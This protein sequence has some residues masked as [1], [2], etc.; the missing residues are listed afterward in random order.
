MGCIVLTFFFLS[1]LQELLHS[2]RR[3]SLKVLSFVQSFQV[4]KQNNRVDC[5]LLFFSHPVY[6]PSTIDQ[7]PCLARMASSPLTLTAASQTPSVNPR[8]S[9]GFPCQPATSSSRTGSWRSGAAG[10]LLLSTSQLS[11][12]TSPHKPRKETSRSSPEVKPPPPDIYIPD[13]KQTDVQSSVG[14]QFKLPRAPHGSSSV[15]QGHVIDEWC[16]F[17]GKHHITRRQNWTGAQTL[18]LTTRPPQ[19]PKPTVRALDAAWFLNAA[20]PALH[21]ILMFQVLK[22]LSGLL[23]EYASFPDQVCGPESKPRPPR[24]LL[25]SSQVEWS[26]AWYRCTS[27][28]FLLQHP[29][30]GAFSF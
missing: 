1:S 18:S 7:C 28:S 4:R 20:R 24:S 13:N 8:R 23:W 27:P 10:P 14:H 15:S 22:C 5:R 17:A 12:R 26:D 29:T 11:R 2:S 21:I 6:L 3:L 30:F 16:Y 19:P 25:V 9:R